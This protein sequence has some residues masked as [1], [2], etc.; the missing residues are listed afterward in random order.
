[1][2][3]QAAIVSVLAVS[4]AL[5]GGVTE[6]AT[7]APTPTC[8][9]M[10]QEPSSFC[11]T[12]TVS[13][14]APGSTPGTDEHDAAAPADL[15]IDIANV[16]PA[17]DA[18]GSSG[19]WLDHV[20]VNLLSGLDGGPSIAPRGLPNNLLVAGST[21]GCAPSGNDFS[22]CTAG[23]GTFYANVSG[24][25]LDDGL[26]SGTFGIQ[27]IANVTPAPEGSILDW[28]VTVDLCIDVLNQSCL[29]GAQEQTFDILSPAGLPSSSSG[30]TLVVPTRT[31]SFSPFP[32]VTVDPGSF[33]TLHLHVDGQ[34]ANVDGAL[35]PLAK[36][37]TVV[38]VPTACGT[39]RTL[40][41]STDRADAIAEAGGQPAAQE[42]SQLTSYDIT[43]CPTA[44]FANTA[45]RLSTA[46]FDASASSAG[47]V[48]RTIA[49]YQWNFG[50]GTT[51]TTSKP[52]VRHTF[53]TPGDHPVWLT[54]VDSA[55]AY[56][57]HAGAI[58]GSDMLFA[59]S[60][61]S[62][63]AGHA[64]TLSGLLHRWQ[65]TTGLGGRAVQIRRCDAKG[66]N[67]H[68]V[69]TLT[70][71]TK[72]ASRGA[73]QLTVHPTAPSVYTATFLGGSGYL[74]VRKS[75][76]VAIRATLSRTG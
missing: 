9:P 52:T 43:G 33:D 72:A 63:V 5:M 40:T 51:A 48:D 17:H 14:T 34:S 6:A 69:A 26:H 71:S 32:G 70:T 44:R 25:M 13:L 31:A 3:R 10:P 75:R 61:K 65:Q 68:L 35:D 7:P 50:D 21:G 57:F 73:F 39:A 20:A 64:L 22:G 11:V 53:E 47:L 23:T 54:V 38:Q 45:D 66:G 4:A 41:V 18:D 8:S 60:A 59:S 1:M 12:S 2:R 58:K 42:L 19:V 76:S 62:V 28:K 56:G 36:P 27:K 55:G 74:G 30:S 46:T 16:S 24:T 15:A 37:R 67:C 29:G 49:H